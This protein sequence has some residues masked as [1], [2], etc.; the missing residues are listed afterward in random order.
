MIIIEK[1]TSI[2]RNHR[3]HQCN[4]KLY[5]ELFRNTQNLLE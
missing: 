4:V 3:N 2:G 5:N 1:S